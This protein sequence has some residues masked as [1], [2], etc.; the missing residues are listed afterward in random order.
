M[1]YASTRNALTK[2][3]GSTVFTDSLFA[4][5]KSDVTPEAYAAHKRHQA[6][7]KPLSAREQEMADIRAA[8]REAST[9]YEGSRARQN[10]LGNQEVEYTWA[11]DAREVVGELRAGDGNRLV[12]LVSFFQRCR[13]LLNALIFAWIVLENKRVGT[14]RVEQQCTHR[15]RKCALRKYTSLGALYVLIFLFARRKE[16]NRYTA[17]CLFAW[18]DASPNRR[19]IGQWA[20]YCWLILTSIRA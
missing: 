8:E 19:D 1:L 5:A 20:T 15:R 13:G 9:A 10:H 11:E 6:A 2:S 16:I 14:D 7:P 18:Q 17:Y 4:T 12:I 3:L